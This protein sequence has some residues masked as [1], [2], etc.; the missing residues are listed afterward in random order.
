MLEN[1][2]EEAG[3]DWNDELGPVRNREQLGGA[4]TRR[5]EGEREE[6]GEQKCNCNKKEL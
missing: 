2:E 4:S 6:L 5:A 3:C 1:F